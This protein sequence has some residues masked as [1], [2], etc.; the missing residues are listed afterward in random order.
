MASHN[1]ARFY[2]DE[3]LSA[4]EQVLRDVWQV[5]KA[6]NPYPNWNNDPELRQKLAFQLMA[7]ADCGV[8]DPC[9]LRARML[10]NLPLAR[11][12]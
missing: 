2:D 5:L 8:R 7:L 10:E 6:H 12:H 4:L 11:A 9:E 1:P 3:T